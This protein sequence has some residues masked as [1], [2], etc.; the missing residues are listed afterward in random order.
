MLHRYFQAIVIVSLL[1]SVP[2]FAGKKHC[3]SY[4]EKLRNVQ[5]LQRQGHNLKRS[6]N[7]NKRE[8]KLRKKWWQCERGLLKT[9][10]NSKT[11]KQKK[12]NAQQ[13]QKAQRE[14]RKALIND[15]LMVN[16][17]VSPFQTS[18]AVVI[19]SRYQGKQLQAWLKYYHQPK[20]CSR[21]KTTKQFVFCVE[22]RRIQQLA[23][24]KTMLQ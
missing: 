23:F 16:A 8:A 20:Q 18:A 9:T 15:S 3:Q 22:D 4:L 21:P 24:E 10:K 2:S 17:S 12:R 6:E 5:S 11:K 1:F 13:K 7:L 14:K 19:K